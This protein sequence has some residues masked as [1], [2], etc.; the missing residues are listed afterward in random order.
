M[1]DEVVQVRMLHLSATG[2]GDVP[3]VAQV[4]LED[5]RKLLPQEDEV[6]AGEES[7]CGLGLM[8]V[9]SVHVLHGAALTGRRGHA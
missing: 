7:L 5:G 1:L 8:E 6:L 9:D 4:P 3:V 2:S